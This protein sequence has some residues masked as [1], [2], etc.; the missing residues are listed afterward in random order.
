MF[1]RQD[2][3]KT[4]AV[5][6]I[7]NPFACSCKVVGHWTRRK[8]Q[9]DPDWC[10]HW[11]NLTFFHLPLN[12][13]CFAPVKFGSS[14]PALIPKLGELHIAEILHLYRK[15]SQ[16]KCRF[17]EQRYCLDAR[18]EVRIWTQTTEAPPR[19][20]RGE[21][22]PQSPSLLYF[23]Y[24]ICFIVMIGRY[25]LPHYAYR[26]P[27]LTTSKHSTNNAH[28]SSVRFALS[29]NQNIICVCTIRPGIAPKII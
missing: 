16:W 13:I 10:K 6:C 17:V 15:M 28:T 19:G 3:L 7:L 4:G 22:S 21:K 5:D 9:T 11:K 23:L 27:Y 1:S 14:F 24:F 18:Q 2:I 20:G 26:S 25:I 29:N 8:K 12:K